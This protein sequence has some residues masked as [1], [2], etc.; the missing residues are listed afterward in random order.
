MRGQNGLLEIEYGEY[1]QYVASS[2][3][4][5]KLESDYQKGLLTQTGKTY[6]VD[7]T[8]YNHYSEGFHPKII[9]EYLCDGKKYV[10]VEANSSFCGETFQ[11][12]NG[13]RYKDK[14]QVWVKVSPIR[15]IV[16]EEEN[17]AVSRNLLVSGIRYHAADNTLTD[18]ASSEMKQ[19]LDNCFSKEIEKETTYVQTQTVN[20]DSTINR[21]TNPYQ[22]SF[23]KVS[24][25]EIIKG[26]IESDVAVFC[27]ESL[28]QGKV[29]E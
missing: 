12:S 22:F 29:L 13:E 24:E 10:R 23:D 8:Y 3:E 9:Q 21:R 6:T 25:E 17:L 7:E 1:P 26:A 27:M 18:F 28:V 4:T 5:A 16:D 15:W 11:L 19:Y 2:Y 14:D 20:V